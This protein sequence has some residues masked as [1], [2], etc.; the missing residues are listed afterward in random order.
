[1]FVIYQVILKL[2]EKD[3]YK[4]VQEFQTL[5]DA[6]SFLREHANDGNFYTVVME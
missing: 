3:T 1:M 6:E 2:T 4:R 5:E